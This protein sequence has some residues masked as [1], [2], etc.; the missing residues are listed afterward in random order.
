MVNYIGLLEKVRDI[1]VHDSVSMI[2]RIK[3][4]FLKLEKHGFDIAAPRSTIDK[5][6]SIKERQTRA[7]EELKVAAEKD[8]KRRKPQRRRCRTSRKED[9]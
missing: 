5:L 2:N 7:L 6:L 9:S 8:N 1:R 3:E 4:C